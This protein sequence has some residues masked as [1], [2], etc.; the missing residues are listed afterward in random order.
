MAFG[1][2]AFAGN[3]FSDEMETDLPIEATRWQRNDRGEI[4][5][6][7]TSVNPSG[8]HSVCLPNIKANPEFSV[9]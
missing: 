6:V 7:A 9:V 2:D 8:S 4:E 5:L 3:A 1:S